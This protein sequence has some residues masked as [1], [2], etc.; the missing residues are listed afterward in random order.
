MHCI[1]EC[2]CIG[3]IPIRTNS[4]SHVSLALTRRRP[5]RPTFYHITPQL[6]T[7]ERRRQCWST[8]A[9][10]TFANFLYGMLLLRISVQ[11][12]VGS[13]GG[14]T[15]PDGAVKYPKAMKATVTPKIFRKGGGLPVGRMRCPVN[16]WSNR[17]G[18]G[19]GGGFTENN[20]AVRRVAA[21]PG[22]K[23]GITGGIMRYRSTDCAAPA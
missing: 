11:S 21:G 18:P 7:E 15:M 5:Q 2:G 10:S 20:L 16:C 12:S 19:A 3:K 4:N 13:G 23:I 9:G 8:T 22:L 17:R 14:T 1:F 6:R